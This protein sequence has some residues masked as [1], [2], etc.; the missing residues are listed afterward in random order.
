M[1]FRSRPLR[2][3]VTSFADGA[4][5]EVWIHGG[6]SNVTPPRF[7]DYLYASSMLPVI[8]RMPRI[9]DDDADAHVTQFADG[10]MRHVTPVAS[11][12]EACAPTQKC[13]E[14]DEP[15]HESIQQLF[16]I[17]TSPYDVGSEQFPIADAECCRRG[18]Q[19]FTKGPRVMRRAIALMAD[20]RTIGN[21]F[22]H[23]SRRSTFR[24]GPQAKTGS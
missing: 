13:G 2:V 23:A 19:L 5:R 9:A 20:T 22:R 8:A 7:M 18:T 11:Y 3:G 24:P 4:Y 21:R 12:F 10:G 14:Q 17:G 16:V 15:R 6:S 1:L